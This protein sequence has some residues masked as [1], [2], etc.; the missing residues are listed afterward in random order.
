[1]SDVLVLCYHGVSETWPAEI[2]VTPHD[3]RAQLD[4]LVRSGYRGATFTEAVT[5]PP[6]KRTLAVTFDDAYR[7]VLDLAL[8]ILDGLGLPGTVFA[9]TDFAESGRPL[10][11]DGISMWAEGRHAHELHGLSW[12]ELAALETAGWEIGSHT[13]THPRLTQLDDDTL[14]EELVGSRA[15]CERALGHPCLSIAYPYGDVDER[16]MTASEKAGYVVAAGLVPVRRAPDRAHLDV[17]RVGVYL[18]D[19]IRRFGLKTSPTVRRLRGAIRRA[20]GSRTAV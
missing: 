10:T 6:F 4:R 3:L 17:L 1:M 11:W 14:A 16:V 9:V 19:T 13:R 20:P 5:A 7:S 15:A 2:A 12:A 8:P 18:P